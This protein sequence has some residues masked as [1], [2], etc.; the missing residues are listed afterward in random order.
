[1]IILRSIAPLRLIEG[2]RAGSVR[3]EYA[4]GLGPA[5]TAAIKAFVEAGGTL[6]TLDASS[7]LAI[8]TLGLPVT[9][10]VRGLPADKF[11]CPGSLVRLDVERSHPLGFGMAA[12]TAAFFAFSS[13]WDVTKAPG[14]RVAAR[15]GREGLLLSGWL[16]GEQVIAGQPAVVEVPAGA[17]RVVLI[18]FRAQHRGQA[19]ATFRL[20]F[21]SLLTN[22]PGG[23][24]GR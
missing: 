21:N 7:Q 19:H 14:A 24:N 1:M 10:L 15:Y 5:G 23:A 20:L 18:G 17:G 22:R 4:G 3:D 13:A 6:V 11:F 16:E 12:D 9:N 2:Y 8:D